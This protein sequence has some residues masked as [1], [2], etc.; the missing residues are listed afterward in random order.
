L[1]SAWLLLRYAQTRA[2][3]QPLV[4]LLCLSGWVTGNVIILTEN[5]IGFPW[6]AVQGVATLCAIGWLY[7]T[8]ERSS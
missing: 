4:V 7:R 6:A 2:T 5:D 3:V 8:H 1:A